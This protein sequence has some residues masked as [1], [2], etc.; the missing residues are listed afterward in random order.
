MRKTP[1]VV[2]GVAVAVTAA[3]ALTACAGSSSSSGGDDAGQVDEVSTEI[4]DED[5]TLTLAYT[6]DPP[7][8]ALVDGFT[9]E[10]PNVKIKTEMTPFNDYVK[11]IKLGMSSD[12]PPDIAQYNPGAMNSLVPAGLI[13]DL[14]PY[15]DAYGWDDKFP[16]ASLEVLSSDKKAK[17][18]GT[19]GLYAVPGGL[20]VLGVFYNKS[21]L[22]TAGV[23]EPPSTL[24]DFEA[25]MEKV[26]ASGNDPLRA[27]ALQVGG[28]H[29]WN[30][31][32]NVIGDVDDYRSWVYGEPD[33]TIETDAARKA[34]D[35]VVD[36]K[37]KGYLPASANATTTEDAQAQFANGESAFLITGNWATA[38]LQEEMGDNV[39]FFLMPTE[40]GEPVKVASGA[41]VAYA[42][43]SKTKHP[44]VAAAFLD[45][46]ATEEAAKAQ[47][48][49]G[50]MPVN[51]EAEVGVQGLGEDVATNFA[52]VSDNDGI[53]PFPDFASPGMI[54][55][56]TPGIQGLI[57][58]SM[59]TDEF[60]ASLQESWNKHHGS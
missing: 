39:G 15:S 33:A 12:D 3:L 19:G 48:D 4:T 5:V 2:R 52:T 16:P 54:D 7:T 32:L 59:T 18:F 22:K 50:F 43:S 10:H 47:M 37:K 30:A 13:Y 11:S 17:Q 9:E 27:G 51:T 44:D 42:I 35:K 1:P 36:W 28:F 41:S 20:S 38:A 21:M 40:S 8:E 14:G 57:S 49:G 45:Y 6:N 24:S 56:L 46:M 26:K 23:A 53:V 34:T 60:L 31:L 25:A 58:G 29:V 55:K